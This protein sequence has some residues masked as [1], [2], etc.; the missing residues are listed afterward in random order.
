MNAALLVTQNPTWDYHLYYYI[1]IFEISVDK[2]IIL[3]KQQI[4]N[5]FRE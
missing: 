5:L 1:K 3:P 2:E 4:R